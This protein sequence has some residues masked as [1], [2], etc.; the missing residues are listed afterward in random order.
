M[1]EENQAYLFSKSVQVFSHSNFH[2][3]QLLHLTHRHNL[4]LF[5]ATSSLLTSRCPQ[6]ADFRLLILL[7]R[8]FHLFFLGVSSAVEMDGYRLSEL[9]IDILL[10]KT[11]KQDFADAYEA[12]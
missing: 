2:L 6:F 5:D 8:F 11:S 1:N 3:H 12:R 7:C 4:L 9:R 10:D